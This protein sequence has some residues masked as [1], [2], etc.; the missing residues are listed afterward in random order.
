MTD[1]TKAPTDAGLT[2]SK[3]AS[4]Q[5]G[6][7]VWYT[8]GY[9]KKPADNPYPMLGF[10]DQAEGVARQ[11]L[12]SLKN[13]YDRSFASAPSQHFTV[14]APPGKEYMP[15]QLA[16][17][18]Y[19]L[20]KNNALIG[21][22]PGLGK[23]IQAVGVANA[24]GAKRVLVVAPASIRLNWQ[25][26]IKAWSTIPRVSTYP[27]LKASNGVSPHANYVIT[28]YDLTRNTGIHEALCS[29]EWDL[30]VLDEAHYLKSRDAIRTR[31]MFGGGRSLPFRD[32]WLQQKTQRILALTGTP[33]PNRPREC[34]T[35][36]RGLCW[37]AIDWTSWDDFC[38]RYNP[39]SRMA[40]GHILEMKGRLPELRSRLRCNFM[41]RRHK[42]DVLTS[43]PD[44]RYEMAYVEPDG[45]IA[46]VL[47]KE[48]L[49][50]F[51][52]N[53]LMS[54][55]E[56]NGEIATIRREMGE[57]KVPRVVQHIKYLLDLVEVPKLVMF[58]H[59]RV[60]MDMLRQELERYGVVEV[61][62]GMST[63]AKQNSVDNFVNNADYRIFSGQLD[64]AGFGIDGLQ[65]VASRVIFA[66]PAWTPGTNEQAVDRC[67]RHGQ[68][69]NVVAE[70]L[71][72]EG[73]FDE[74]ILGPMIG[75]VGIIHEALDGVV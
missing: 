34:Y 44:K 67:H 58:S 62:G 61:R 42:K 11:R 36:A 21:D 59:H 2:L 48:R 18:E 63:Q 68:H 12:A 52:P 17:I 71:I 56:I 25:R 73:S 64:A 15:F 60:V 74:R 37:D 23:T 46:A 27:I 75:K 29:T 14:P 20:D 13:E 3:S 10:F 47:K 30:I 70:F 16:G 7:K 8:S 54:S 69:D 26:E 31:A 50:D 38:F 41:V 35:L 32:R 72:A 49:L 53:I 6:E 43:L 22:E 5:N 28:S 55:F 4:G 19:A 1:D 33:L 24:I 45:A 40:T 39:S 57:A 9:D 66:E 51:D 65:K